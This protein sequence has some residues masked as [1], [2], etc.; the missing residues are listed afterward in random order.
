MV[1]GEKG[2]RGRS[3][4]AW[5]PRQQQERSGQPAAVPPWAEPD[6]QPPPPPSQIYTNL[7]PSTPRRSVMQAASPVA[8]TQPHPSPTHFNRPT[9]GASPIML[10]R[11]LFRDVDGPAR[12]RSVDSITRSAPWGET[13]LRPTPRTESPARGPPGAHLPPWATVTASSPAM[14]DQPQVPP[15]RGDQPQVPP[16]RGDQPQVPPGR[17]DQPQV[18]PG[19]GDQPQV[20]PGRGDQ[21]QVPPGR[22]DQPQVPPGRGD[23]PQVPP[24]RGDQPQ[25]TPGRGDQPQVPPGRGDQPQVPPGRGDQPQ[26]PPGRGDQPQVPPGRG[27]QPQVPPGR[28]DQPQG[29]VLSRTTVIS[30]LS[31]ESVR[32]RRV[33]WQREV[34]TP[35]PPPPSTASQFIARE[36]GPGGQGSEGQ[37]A[38]GPP[39]PSGPQKDAPGKQLDKSSPTPW[40]KASGGQVSAGQVSAGQVSAGQVSAGQVSAGQVSAGQVSAGQMSAGQVSAGQV[41]ASQISTGQVSAGQVSASQM[42]TGQVSAGQVSAGQVSA[43]QMSTGQVSAGKTAPAHYPRQ[44]GDASAVPAA[45]T[46]SHQ[47]QPPHHLTGHRAPWRA[48]PP[49][50]EQHP[51]GTSAAPTGTSDTT[52]ELPKSQTAAEEDIKREAGDTVAD[53]EPSWRR[54]QHKSR[55]AA[56]SAAAAP[57]Q[58]T[59]KPASASLPSLKKSTIADSPSSPAPDVTKLAQSVPSPL[60]KQSSPVLTSANKPG[61][62]GPTSAKKPTSAGPTSAKK[63]SSAGPTSAKKSASAVPTENKPSSALPPENKSASDVPAENKPASALPTEN[64]PSSALP[65][66]NKPASAVPASKKAA[67]TPP[68]ECASPAPVAACITAASASVPAGMVRGPPAA[69]SVVSVAVSEDKA[70]VERE[71]RWGTSPP[72]ASP[73]TTTHSP[74]PLA[75]PLAAV[76]THSPT[77]PLPPKYTAAAVI[78][79]PTVPQVGK[80]AG[81]PV[82]PTPAPVTTQP[83][84]TPPFSISST[85]PQPLAASGGSPVPSVSE[86]RAAEVC[87]AE[88]PHAMPIPTPPPAPD[89]K[90]LKGGGRILSLSG[91]AVSPESSPIPARK[92]VSGASSAEFQKEPA[93]VVISRD[94]MRPPQPEFP[95]PPPEEQIE[96]LSGSGDSAILPPPGFSHEANTGAPSGFTTRLPCVSEQGEGIQSP[97]YVRESVTKR[98]KAFEKQ[99][100]KEEEPPLVERQ[101]PIARPVAPWVK[102]TSSG[103][104]QQERFWDITSPE[105]EDP[106]VTWPGPPASKEFERTKSPSRAASPREAQQTGTAVAVPAAP[107]LKTGTAAT[108]PAAPP[109]KTGTAATVPAAPPLKTGTAATVPAAPPLKTGTAAP[110]LKTG[111]AAA[112]PKIS[113]A[114]A[115]PGSKVAAIP[116]SIT[117]A[118][119]ARSHPRP[120]AARR[121]RSA[122]TGDYYAHYISPDEPRLVKMP[123]DS[124]VTGS[125]ADAKKISTPTKDDVLFDPWCDPKNPRAI[126]FQDVSAAAFK[127]KSGIMNT[128]CTKSH[129]SSFTDMEIFF[130]KEFNQYTGSF[131]ERGARYT[132]LML[133]EQQQKKGVIAA[134]AGNHALALCYHGQDLSIPVTVVMPLVAPIMKV[135]ACRQYGANV[136]VKGNDIGECREYAL[137]MA[138]DQGLLYI[139]GYDHPHI[140]A[141]QGTMGLEIV[142]QVPNIDAVVIPVGGA[143]LIA[144]VALA[145]KALYPHVQVIGVEAERCASFSAAMKAGRPV[146]VK[147]E[148]TLADGLAVPM[149]GVNAFATASRLVDKVVT[150]RE[151]W[152]A[153]A[154]LRLVE[155]EKAVVEGA[156][157]TAL[158]AILAGELPELKGKRVV[159]PLCGGNIDTTVL[160]R[161]LER[162]LAADGRLVKFTVTVSDRPGG[163]AELTRLMANLGV[164]IKDMVHE[165]AWIRSDIFSVEVKVMAETKDFEHWLEL[166]AALEQR[167]ERV[168]FAMPDLVHEDNSF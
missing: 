67:S 100:S 137:K 58:T 129:M 87:L 119:V 73:L 163:I 25:V 57:Q 22:G 76:S 152:I 69:P 142:E 36:P 121:Q 124:N 96:I 35:Q 168:R 154:I 65:T 162:G 105:S 85:Q 91:G 98:I 89:A 26:V 131:K 107:P 11:S 19:R 153:I 134:S 94:T 9:P 84:R 4:V 42:S 141:G 12:A 133:P 74:I 104:V 120:P 130:K 47:P 151:E 66:E 117:A 54:H 127:I 82:L 77:P 144:G 92:D 17:G 34:A 60:T 59:V 101:L 56:S 55:P 118:K 147:A 75:P 28:G 70:G 115:S 16:G 81:T 97:E 68:S 30:S 102:R 122:S 110:P 136:I 165:R 113:A 132:L 46:D 72:L 125:A 160:G 15:G 111:T 40:R 2:E 146:Y 20:P 123:A 38:P 33:V 24:G 6:A 164:S 135:Q 116:A 83:M 95:P 112:P 14:G 29:S 140:L 155:C 103:P 114:V 109:L 39:H 64:K 61:S 106:E 10:R 49:A 37:G 3:R 156:G 48:A 86:A 27:D 159:I 167:Y 23:Q 44:E 53:C 166:K 32:E 126:S 139:N 99:A 108:V 150:V 128:P 45:A 145:V 31:Q 5:L 18:P 8:T 80:P 41:S 13:K 138:K 93:A 51:A 1:E 90:L 43:S 148:S 62:A 88:D 158:A 78:S 63:P 157:A 50:A 52:K 79:A 149:V 161:C 143:G 7:S 71:V 21:P